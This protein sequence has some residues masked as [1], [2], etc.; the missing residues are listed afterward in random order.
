MPDRTNDFGLWL[1]ITLD[2]EG[3]G[4]ARKLARA[5]GV[6]DGAV[7]QWRKPPYR[8]PSARNVQDI[9]KHLGVDAMR[10]LVTAG[11]LDLEG[12]E[13]FEVPESERTLHGM[14]KAL[15]RD[16]LMTKGDVSAILD[17]YTEMR[18]RRT[19]GRA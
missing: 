9:A 10:L 6:S 8:Q 18:K 2:N 17:N 1:D 19:N 7:T 15:E 12:V 16:G 4:A 5:V 11:H 3:P 14:K 13:P